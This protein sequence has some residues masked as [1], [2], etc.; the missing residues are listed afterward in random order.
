MNLPDNA[1]RRREDIFVGDDASAAEVVV[2]AVPEGRL[3]GDGALG[4]GLAAHHA[5]V[6]QQVEG[7]HV[8]LAVGRRGL[9]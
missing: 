6:H 5:R 4:R 7:A 1:M 3:P 2:G 8:D 9:I